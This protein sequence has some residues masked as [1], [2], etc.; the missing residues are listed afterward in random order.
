MRKSEQYFSDLID[1]RHIIFQGERVANVTTHFAFKGCVQTIGKLIDMHH[2]KDKH[3]LLYY[4]NNQNR[5][6]PTSYM[7]PKNKEDI[8]KKGRA[9]SIVARATGG[10]MAR[11]PDFLATLL[12]SWSAAADVFGYRKPAFGRNITDYYYFSRE[13][14]LVHS[15][16]ISDPPPDR[17][18]DVAEDN[19]LSLRKIGETK[20]G[21]IVK[22]IKMLA[23][24]APVSD[25][26][27]IYPFRQLQSEEASQALA[28]AIPVNTKGLKFICRSPIANGNCEFDH[29]LSERF[30]EMDALCIFE[31]VL[32]PHDRIFIDGDVVF[33]NELRSKTGMV[34]YVS[35]QI[36]C[37]VAAK[38]EFLLGL[39]SLIATYSGRDQH[40]SVQE[41]LGE[42]S[43]FAELLR[44]LVVAAETESNLDLFGN[45]IPG[46][47]S[48]GAS[49]VLA[50]EIYR[51]SIDI[52]RLVGA[53][54]I[55][56]HPGEMDL[57]S[58]DYPNI[59]KYFEPN[60]E[61]ALIH[62]Q[63]LKLA[64]DLA[65]DTFGGRQLLYETF[66]IGAPQA[67]KIRFYQNYKKIKEA[68]CLAKSF[69][70][71]LGIPDLKQ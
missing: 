36:T 49:S 30:D 15:H 12:A 22:G 13:K 33:A 9:F 26:L 29:P 3:D 35:H 41:M 46:T 55:I 68:E 59:W 65:S 69:I 4:C 6:F 5:Y 32:I 58:E 19:K 25:E 18:L 7:V 60:R 50:A 70:V 17:F 67:I 20:E 63:L 37:R 44:S 24:L 10:L 45:F 11:T 40:A 8:E 51:K 38:S 42:L 34:A 47:S 48:M 53:S 62:I 66:Y 52:L 71:P 56:M 39:T 16:A 14:N 1:N 21:I 2:E 43:A 64:S 57:T 31:D 23:T 61:N 27:I 54:G 28:F